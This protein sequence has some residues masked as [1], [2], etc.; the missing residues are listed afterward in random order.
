MDDTGTASLE[1]IAVFLSGTEEIRFA[2]Q[3]RVE[4]YGW[5]ERTLVRHQY[6]SLG[7]PNKG[8]VW[9]YVARMTGMS[10]A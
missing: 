4:V 1:Q 9:R 2:G 10:R 8:L 6:A 3:R 7:R 5:V